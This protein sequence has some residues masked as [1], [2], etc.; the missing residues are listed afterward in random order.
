MK[1]AKYMKRL[2]TLSIIFL[3]ILL[4]GI[5]SSLFSQNFVAIG[6]ENAPIKYIKGTGSN[7]GLYVGVEYKKNGKSLEKGVTGEIVVGRQFRGHTLRGAG[8]GFAK[9]NLNLIYPTKLPSPNRIYNIKSI[10]NMFIL[11]SNRNQSFPLNNQTQV[12]DFPIKPINDY[13]LETNRVNEL[14]LPLLCIDQREQLPPDIP[15]INFTILTTPKI[16]EQSYVGIY[17]FDEYAKKNVISKLWYNNGEFAW[18]QGTLTLAEIYMV[19]LSNFEIDSTTLN[20]P[21]VGYYNIVNAHLS[22]GLAQWTLWAA[23]NNQNEQ[24]FLDGFNF[25]RQE[26]HQLPPVP[27]DSIVDLY[28]LNHL[29]FHMAKLSSLKANFRGPEGTESIVIPNLTPYAFIQADTDLF[30]MQ[31]NVNGIELSAQYSFDPDGE[32]KSYKWE[33]DGGILLNSSSVKIKYKQKISDSTKVILSVIDNEGSECKDTLFV[34][35]SQGM[36]TEIKHIKDKMDIPMEIKIEQNFPNPFN[37]FTLIP[38]IL[39]TNGFIEIKITNILGQEIR[40]FGYNNFNSGEY[41]IKWDGRDNMNQD[42]ATGVY[43]LQ[44]K[45][46]S[47]IEIIKLVLI[48]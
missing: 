27:A 10:N 26:Y 11:Q 48:R 42:V 43:L 1:E 37:T 33:F 24:T 39:Y 45:S 29:V 19:L 6:S 15:E 20:D 28:F 3:C 23:I 8:Q 38:F 17:R 40:N 13:K 5:D 30:E 12:A 9:I 35:Y 21:P 25:I 16:I 47:F 32:I 7:I 46:R 2:I 41:K 18:Y 36:I 14:F 44:I 34:P 31:N 4:H 22:P